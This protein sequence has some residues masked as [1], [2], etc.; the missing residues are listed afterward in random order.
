VTNIQAPIGLDN[1]TLERLNDCFRSPCDRMPH[2]IAAWTG[3]RLSDATTLV[4]MLYAGGL[5]RLYY[6]VFHT[7]VEHPVDERRFED[8]KVKE[9]PWTCP[10]CEEDVHDLSELWYDKFILTEEPIV[11]EREVSGS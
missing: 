5:A 9:L 6:R 8:G 4:H 2:Q 10:E 11:F 1:R 7:C 3:M